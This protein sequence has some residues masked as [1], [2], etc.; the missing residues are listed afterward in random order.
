MDVKLES[1]I[2]KIKKDGI[3]EANKASEA[4][5]QKA[6]EK[7]DLIGAESKKEAENIIENAKK[8]AQKL[9]ANTESSLKQA[10]RDLSLT[11]KSEIMA[12]LDRG[13]KKKISTELSPEFLKDLIVKL[14][15][16]FSHKKGEGVEVLVSEKDK[17]KVEKL[18]LEALKAE[19]KEVVQI[20]VSKAIECG[21]RIGIKGEN[22]YYDFTDETVL[23]SLKEFLNPAI[24][25]MLE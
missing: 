18:L 3:E 15:D 10:A 13:L 8:E 23:E 11:L 9:K 7:S 21:F 4:I 12:L 17:T 14:V 25:A 22:L 16:K 5:I 2:D 6:K 1:L 20:K 19:A 24:S